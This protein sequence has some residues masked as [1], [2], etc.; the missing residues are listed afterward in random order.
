MSFSWKS[1]TGYYLPVRGAGRTLPLESTLD[2]LRPIL[3]DPKVAKIG[4]NIKYDLIVMARHGVP[5]DGVE[6]DTQNY[7]L[8]QGE[9]QKA[10][11]FFKQGLGFGGPS[12]LFS[13]KKT[14]FYHDQNKLIEKAFS[15]DTYMT[16]ALSAP[17]GVTIAI[18]A[19]EHHNYLQRSTY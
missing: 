10:D 19:Y 11:H 3:T 2:A 4:Q 18:G 5:V 14:G 16:S 17:G 12:G 15:F 13:L 8:A 1:G 9:I 7:P 6:F